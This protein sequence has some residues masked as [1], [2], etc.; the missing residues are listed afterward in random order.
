MNLPFLKNKNISGAIMTTK[1]RPSDAPE[2]SE[3]EGNQGLM[4]AAKDLTTAIQ[5]GDHKAV[6][7]ALEAAF[8]ILDAA[9]HEEGEHFN[10]EQE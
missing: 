1:V 3:D 6:A 8:Q 5:A 9:P 4:E 7:Q 10:E 2:T